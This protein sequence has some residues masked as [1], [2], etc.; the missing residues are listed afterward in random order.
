MGPDWLTS[1]KEIGLPV[2][3]YTT[4]KP[5]LLPNRG[6]NGVDPLLAPNVKEPEYGVPDPT[7]VAL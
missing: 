6:P 5:V 7:G 2:P 4:S 1:V 3:D